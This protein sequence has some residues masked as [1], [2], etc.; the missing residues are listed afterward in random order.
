MTYCDKGSVTEYDVTCICINTITIDTHFYYLV[1]HFL[2]FNLI[3][4]FHMPLFFFPWT[5]RALF[6]PLF[7]FFLYLLFSIPI[8]GRCWTSSD[9][10]WLLRPIG[11]SSFDLNWNSQMIFISIYF[12]FVPK[13]F[14]N[15]FNWK[16]GSSS[17]VIV[18]H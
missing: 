14:P 6:C 18:N 2:C 5:L 4:K 9:P 13:S 12:L 10:V 3:L 15:G 16:K 11:K 17:I 8:Y 7:I 1:F